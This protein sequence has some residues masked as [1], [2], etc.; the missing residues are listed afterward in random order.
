MPVDSPRNKQA[1]IR[2]KNGFTLYLTIKTINKTILIN[3]NHS[4]DNPITSSQ[5]FSKTVNHRLA[6]TTGGSILRLAYF[7]ASILQL[8]AATQPEEHHLAVY[9]L[10]IK[11]KYLQYSC[12]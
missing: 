11:Y 5:M 2:T 7:F 1:I 8:F 9:K 6:A 10:T 4:K 12:Q 3:A